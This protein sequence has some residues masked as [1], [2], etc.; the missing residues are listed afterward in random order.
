MG[1][2][3]KKLIDKITLKKIPI[4]V[5]MLGLDNAGKSTIL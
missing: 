3:F 5:L 1:N 2:S 4:K